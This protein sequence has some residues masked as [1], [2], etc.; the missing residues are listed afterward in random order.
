[1]SQIGHPHRDAV[2]EQIIGLYETRGR[3][4]YDGPVDQIEHG[5]QA[6]LLAQRAGAASALVVAALLHDVGHL[7][8]EGEGRRGDGF[9]E[10]LGARYLGAWFPPTVVTP[11]AQHVDAKRY[12]VTVDPTYAAR[13][14]AS[15]QRSLSLQGG[16][17]SRA[18]ARRFESSPHAEAAIRLR[19]WDDAAKV[20]G[21]AAPPLTSFR[22]VM[23]GL[24]SAERAEP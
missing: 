20:A 2:I 16:P 21:V 22:D 8:E 24:V 23:R 18:E 1:M 12:L 10:R 11:V 19:R 13:L 9:H 6:A 15:S 7:L 5:L 4:S 3:R 17:M 14:S